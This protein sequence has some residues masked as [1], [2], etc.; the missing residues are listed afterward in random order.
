[1]FLL[2][3]TKQLIGEFPFSGRVA[4]S[5]PAAPDKAGQILG[6]EGIKG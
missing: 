2:D 5:E 3:Y 1:M 6:L 4:G